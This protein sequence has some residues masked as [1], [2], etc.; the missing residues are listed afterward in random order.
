MS[1]KLILN[2][3]KSSMKIGRYR[4]KQSYNRLYF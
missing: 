4:I 2:I 1:K 3:S